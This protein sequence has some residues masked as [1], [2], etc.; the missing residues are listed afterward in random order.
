MVDGGPNPP[1]GRRIREFEDKLSGMGFP[2]P[3]EFG[4]S[5]VFPR[6]KTEDERILHKAAMT[7]ET[8]CEEVAESMN[9][10]SIATQAACGRMATPAMWSAFAKMFVF[11]IITHPP[12][13]RQRW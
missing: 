3:E 13:W 5:H 8:H 12:C 2:L 4:K 10:Q 7:Y 1:E 6:S 9:G 11:A